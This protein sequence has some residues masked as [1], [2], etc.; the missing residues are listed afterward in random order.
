MR[1][2]KM[3]GLG[4]N[5]HIAR[6]GRPQ[7]WGV[8]QHTHADGSFPRVARSTHTRLTSV[9]R[10]RKANEH[11][12]PFSSCLGTTSTSRRRSGRS[13]RRR[14][15]ARVRTPKRRLLTS[16]DTRTRRRDARELG[17]LPSAGAR[18]ARNAAAAC[19]EQ[20]HG[21]AAAASSRKGSGG[22]FRDGAL[23]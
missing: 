15:H 22:P 23:V 10:S 12:C 13:R 9:K 14:R 18:R 5:H 7:R 2:K 21:G 20:S 3:T 8:R 4:G 1:W 6:T 17:S 16:I 19:A 11:S